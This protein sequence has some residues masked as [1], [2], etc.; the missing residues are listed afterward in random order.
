MHNGVLT[1]DYTCN[2][3][4]GEGGLDAFFLWNSL[5]DGIALIASMTYNTRTAKLTT[6]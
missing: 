5:V 3:H 4:A 2:V 6:I 1:G